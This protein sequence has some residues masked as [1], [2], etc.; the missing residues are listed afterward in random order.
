MEVLPA[1]D[2]MNGRVVRL[3]KGR[4]EEAKVYG[5]P[6]EFAR[7][8]SRFVD[9]VHVVD[10]DGAFTG[11]PRNLDQ[12]ER[13]VREAGVRVQVG[14][15]FRDLDSVARAYDV[16]VENVVIGTKA[17]DLGFLSEI[18]ER[19]R[20]ITV[21]LDSRGGKVS[22][23]GWTEDLDLSVEEACRVLG[24][25]VNRFVYTCVERDGTLSGAEVLRPP[26]EGEVIYAGGVSSVG[27][28]LRLRDLG[29]S[30][31]IIGKALYEG[32][33]KLEDVLAVL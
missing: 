6:V 24:R 17:L 29:F 33:L 31:V 12:V 23:K 32:L 11:R 1:I 3:T 18:T 16:G 20:G 21:S 7:R 13:I 2:I 15:G 28:V 4:R 30:G 27:D 8:F 19:F 25:Y 14:G 26:C 5:D 22:I 9:K 10:L